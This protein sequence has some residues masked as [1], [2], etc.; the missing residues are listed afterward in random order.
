MIARFFSLLLLLYALGFVLFSVTL[1]RPADA[2]VKTE[3]VVAL[4][5]G[6]GRIE[7]A[8]EVL[9]A[10]RAKHMLIAGADPSVT[11][12]DLV[13]RLGGYQ[14]LVNCCV[15]LGSESYDTRTNAEEAARWLKRRGYRTLRLVTN[16]YHM[17]RAGYEFRRILGDDYR[18]T[19][20][21]VRTEPRFVTL[22]SE[23]NDYLLRRLSVWLDI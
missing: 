10:D 22:F 3:A 11:K 18:I 7:R 15:D 1:G 14:R 16:D 12:K 5:G 23:Y 4:T 13:R 6:P 2:T 8:V 20:D 17:R 9:A 21:A 19:Q